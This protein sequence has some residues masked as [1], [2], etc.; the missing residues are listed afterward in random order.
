MK[1]ELND[2]LEKKS[3]IRSKEENVEKG[4]I[5]INKYNTV[6]VEKEVEVDTFFLLQ[7][8]VGIFSV[9]KF[10]LLGILT[11]GLEIRKLQKR[12]KQFLKKEEK[13]KEKV[14]EELKCI[15]ISESKK[16][17]KKSEIIVKTSICLFCNLSV[18]NSSRC[19]RCKGIYCD[20][21]HQRLHWNVHKVSTVRY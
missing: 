14:M 9:L 18:A 4:D 15:E 13:Q 21:N 17:E 16:K 7:N 6:E 19:S 1:S 12:Q 20:R 3:L 10:A 8:A 11:H 5:N 2:S